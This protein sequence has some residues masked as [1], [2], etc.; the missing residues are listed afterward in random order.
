MAQKHGPITGEPIKG[1]SLCY[2][3]E[4]MQSNATTENY[5]TSPEEDSGGQTGLAECG[6]EQEEPEALSWGKMALTLTW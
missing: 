2:N 5:A 4:E 6:Q 1:C 3:A